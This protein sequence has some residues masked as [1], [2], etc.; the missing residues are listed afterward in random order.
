M[1]DA[2][3]LPMRFGD[4]SATLDRHVVELHELI[5]ATRKATEQQHR[6]MEAHAFALVSDPTRPVGPPER[7]SDVPTIDLAA[8]DLA[9]KQLKKRAQACDAAYAALAAESFRVTPARQRAID[10]AMGRM[11]QALTDQD[12]LPTRAWFKHTIYAPGMLTG[13]GVKTVPGVRE[14]IEARRWD[15]ANRY[16]VITAKVLHGYCLQLDQLVALLKDASAA[17]QT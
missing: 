12:G 3:V 8:L 11:E 17:G 16:V 15:E 14:A 13:Y 5:D 4:F 1:A 10:T 6:L 2:D 9:A 7:D